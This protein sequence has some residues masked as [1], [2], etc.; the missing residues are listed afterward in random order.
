MQ[1]ED[2]T[3]WLLIGSENRV[4]YSKLEQAAVIAATDQNDEGAE[5]S[6]DELDFGML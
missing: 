1:G 4:A 2:K 6:G 3:I 5:T